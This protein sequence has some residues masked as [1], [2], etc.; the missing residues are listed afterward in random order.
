MAH[1]SFQKT[2][3]RRINPFNIVGVLLII[4]F[5]PIIIVNIVIVVKSAIHPDQIPMVFDTAP[6]IVLSPSMTIDKKTG[7]GA[8]NEGDLI[9]IRKVNP[10][11]LNVG[12]IITY[13]EDDGLIVTHRI[14]AMYDQEGN[15]LMYDGE[16]ALETKG[17]YNSPVVSTIKYSQIIGIYKSRIAGIGNMAMF[18]Q[19]PMG[20]L[21]L[22]GIPIFAILL[23][24]WITKNK[25][26]K[27]NEK[28]TAE[29]EA[30]LSLLKQAQAASLENQETKDES[31]L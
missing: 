25:E 26:K 27:K 11:N 16:K 1:Q 12:D 8:F 21:T 22:L 7:T 18:L 3:T 14:I 4:I 9:F 6:L 10:E 23:V 5:L 15:H 19:T 13:K 2:N 30:E 28:K 24:D 29:L 17:D 31:P 20:I